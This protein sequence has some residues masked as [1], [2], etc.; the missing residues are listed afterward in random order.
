LAHCDVKELLIDGPCD[1]L[2]AIFIGERTLVCPEIG[3]EVR[4]IEKVAKRITIVVK[5]E[6]TN[7]FIIASNK[8]GKLFRV[9]LSN[10]NEI[11]ENVSA[12]F[13]ICEVD[14]QLSC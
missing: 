10:I 11:T 13:L 14:L 2:I 3:V 4:N 9:F 6:Q 12:F 8:G 5:N 7:I 1:T